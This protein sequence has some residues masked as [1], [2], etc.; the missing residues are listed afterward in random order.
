MRFCDPGW[1]ENGQIL[2]V[3]ASMSFNVDLNGRVELLAPVRVTEITVENQFSRQT[4]ESQKND[5]TKGPPCHMK[6]LRSP[7]PPASV[8]V[9]R[10]PIDAFR[11]RR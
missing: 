10:L 9:S 8:P 3:L 6:S 2:E 11:R 5:G 7:D 4:T 1:N